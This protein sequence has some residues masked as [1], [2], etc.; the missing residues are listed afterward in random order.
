MLPR[1]TERALPREQQGSNAKKRWASEQLAGLIN[2][3][4]QLT[5]YCLGVLIA[6]AYKGLC[7]GRR[8]PSFYTL[9]ACIAAVHT[10]TGGEP[11]ANWH[12]SAS[13]LPHCYTLARSI[14]TTC[15]T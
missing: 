10:E 15:A 7:D 3:L 8:G 11:D 12:R 2:K 6:Q 1:F 4:L 13:S 14:V 5:E 9:P